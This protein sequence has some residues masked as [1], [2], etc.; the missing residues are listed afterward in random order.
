VSI[1]LRGVWSCMKFELQQMRE[2]VF[3][4]SSILERSWSSWKV[5]RSQW[6]DATL[7][8][9][10]QSK[11]SLDSIR[12][13]RKLISKGNDDRGGKQSFHTGAVSPLL[14]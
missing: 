11:Y 10:L 9:R 4:L 1:N 14:L 5:G 13:R 12:S 2:Q 8:W 3:D 6:V 7:V